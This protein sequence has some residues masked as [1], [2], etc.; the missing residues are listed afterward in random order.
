MVGAYNYAQTF[1]T[2][3]KDKPAKPWYIKALGAVPTLAFAILGTFFLL[4][5]KKLIKSVTLVKAADASTVAQSSKLRLEIKRIIG[6][7]DTLEVSPNSVVLDR[8]LPQS[9]P[10]I[11]FTNYHIKDAGRFTEYYF[12][13]QLTQ[14]QDS[15]LKR[16]NQ[17][18][19]N[20]WPATVKNTKRMFLRDQ[21]AYVRVPGNG[22]F[23]LDLQDS[24]L[25]DG[26]N[27]LARVTKSDVSMDKGLPALIRRFST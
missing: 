17:S 18:F 15:A 25:L 12:S 16:F 7:P 10:T 8:N 20:L 14:K 27:V 19:L 1:L 2:D 22:N 11:N 21:M 13:G 3:E 9:V 26:A 23:K 4:A 5:P 6:K 24:H